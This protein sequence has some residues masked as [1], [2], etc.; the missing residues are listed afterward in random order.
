MTVPEKSVDLARASNAPLVL[1]QQRPSV[2]ALDRQVRQLADS[3]ENW[4][5]AD[6]T[7][8]FSS[9]LT[10]LDAA[11]HP[12]RSPAPQGRPQDAERARSFMQQYADDPSVTPR[13]IA[14]L[15]GWSLATLHTVLKET[16]GTTPG[17]L[18]RSIRLD[19]A[20]QRLSTPLPINLDQIAFDSGFT[21][22]R[23]FR[24]AFQRQYGRTPT[25][26]REELFGVRPKL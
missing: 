7:A 19:R 16:I 23:R 3:S 8:A 14:A 25:Q 21:T 15:C 4:S 24:E 1:D 20:R 9:A 13:A 6:F 5:T 11:L 18:L 2:R 12:H 22:T 17:A 10:L 26:M